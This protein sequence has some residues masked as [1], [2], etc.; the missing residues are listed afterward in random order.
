[1]TSPANPR[2]SAAS[3]GPDLTSLPCSPMQ[4]PSQQRLERYEVF[5]DMGQSFPGAAATSI[6]QR[7][8][9]PGWRYRLRH[10]DL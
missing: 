3:M 2:R 1:M 5:V 10:L 9:A 8:F 7:V 4:R 6:R